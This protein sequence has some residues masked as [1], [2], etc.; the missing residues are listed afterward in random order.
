MMYRLSGDTNRIHVEGSTFFN[1]TKPILHGLCALG[2]AVRAVL[3]SYGGVF[4]YVD[5]KFTNPIFVGDTIAVHMWKGKHPTS[6]ASS[7]TWIRFQVIRKDEMTKLTHVAIDDGV[8]QL[9]MSASMSAER[10]KSK[11]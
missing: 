10:P 4:Q 6:D 7:E 11:L 2:Y 5:C 8:I 1:S 9:N 3:K